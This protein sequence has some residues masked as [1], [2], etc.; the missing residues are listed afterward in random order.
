MLTCNA[1][2]PWHCLRTM[3]L[4]RNDPVQYRD[5][6]EVIVRAMTP[7]RR[8]SGFLADHRPPDRWRRN[9]PLLLEEE[10]TKR[11]AAVTLRAF[12]VDRIV[13]FSQI[14]RGPVLEDPVPLHPVPFEHRPPPIDRSDRPDA[15]TPSFNFPGRD[16]NPA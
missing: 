5:R 7:Q 14:V 16:W 13:A 15:H 6:R 11:R 3:Q 9:S 8:Q 2:A 4:S 1:M 10:N 12:R